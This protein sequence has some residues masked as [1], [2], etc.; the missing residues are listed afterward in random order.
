M[1]LV[2]GLALQPD[3]QY[4]TNPGF[5]EDNTQAFVGGLRLEVGF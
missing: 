2:Q 3:L 1:E 4:I 5:S